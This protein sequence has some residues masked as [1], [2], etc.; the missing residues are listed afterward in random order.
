VIAF[1]DAHREVFGVEPICRVLQFAPSTYWSAKR[2]P[3]YARATRD[4]ELKTQITRVHAENFGVYGARKVWAQLNREGVRVARCTVERLMRDLGL[5]GAVRGKPR[6]ITV[7]DDA[8]QR[9]ADLAERDFRPP[10]PN[11]LRVADVDD[12]RGRRR[13]R[14]TDLHRLTVDRP[15]PG[16]ATRRPPPTTGPTTIAASGDPCALARSDFVPRP[17]SAQGPPVAV[18]VLPMITRLGFQESSCG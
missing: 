6:R 12:R 10:G 13:S 8:D 4:D 16:A 11:R 18:A 15:R 1:I 14:P 17:V 2:R 5:Q 9:P 7:T 3:R